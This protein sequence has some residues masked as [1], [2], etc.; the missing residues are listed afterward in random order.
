MALGTL[1]RVARNVTNLAQACAFYEAALGFLPFYSGE[2]A[3][4]AEALSVTT[5]ASARLRLG[6][7]ELE[8]TECQPAGAPY[9]RD[10]Q[11]DDLLFQHIAV[12]TA[13]IHRAAKQALRAGA[14]AI[15]SYGP[16]L[17]PAESGG[18]WAWKF[19]DPDGHPLELLQFPTGSNGML[20]LGYDHSAIGVSEVQRSI[21]FYTA[22]GLELGHRHL[23]HGVEQDRLDG[24]VVSEVEVVALMPPG[25][26]P[27]VEL[28]CY[29]RRDV[30]ASTEVRANDIA[31]DRLVFGNAPG[32]LALR[33]D[34]D[35][36][37][38]LLDG[39]KR[40]LF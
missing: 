34:P 18:V 21:G 10:W 7:Q 38:L 24:L 16:Q 23:N 11:S 28:L 30:R 37:F 27:H 35:G 9:P 5:V 4:L 12:V 36:H 39:R 13:D 2:D 14:E 19:R 40:S 22:L 29:K 32:E 26:P 20:H 15:S 1:L 31:A 3:A 6:G 33:E 17:L 8:L 25:A